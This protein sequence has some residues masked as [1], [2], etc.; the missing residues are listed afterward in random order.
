[1]Y[2]TLTLFSGSGPDDHVFVNYVDHGNVGIVG[3]PGEGH[4]VS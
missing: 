3:F 4:V 2:V 1:M